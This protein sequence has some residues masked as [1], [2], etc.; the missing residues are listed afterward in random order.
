MTK[1]S[2]LPSGYYPSTHVILK[3]EDHD[4]TRVVLHSILL[5]N[6]NYQQLWQGLK[7]GWVILMRFGASEK[8]RGGRRE[9]ADR[10]NTLKIFIISFTPQYL[11]SCFGYLFTSSVNA[12]LLHLDI[13]SLDIWPL[14]PNIF[15]HL[16]RKYVR[17]LNLNIYLFGKYIRSLNL[18]IYLFGRTSSNIMCHCSHCLVV[19]FL[20]SSV[21]LV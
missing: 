20:G 19:G 13:Y 3:R 9:G 17:S 21:H 6:L 14:K 15:I 5:I 2:H 11:I 8:G 7:R 4:D 1:H 18:Y 10:Q 16:M 12:H